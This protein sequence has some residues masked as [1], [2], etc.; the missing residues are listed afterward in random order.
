MLFW[1]KVE[2]LPELMAPHTGRDGMEGDG[3]GPIGMCLCVFLDNKY[4][5]GFT[6]LRA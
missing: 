1:L 6:G 5:Y 4:I 2:S 3:C